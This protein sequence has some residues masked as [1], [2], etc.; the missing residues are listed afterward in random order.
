MAGITLEQAQA[1]LNLY[2]DAEAKVLSGQRV[3]LGDKDITRADLD[4]V[5]KGVAT[6][7]Q[8]VIQLSRTTTGLRVLE[9]IPR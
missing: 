2:L 8:R 4:F 5:Q 6:W 9:A 7:N 1:Q 3:R